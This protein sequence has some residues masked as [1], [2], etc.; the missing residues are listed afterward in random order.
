MI[1]QY[2]GAAVWR[3]PVSLTGMLSDEAL[4]APDTGQNF[5]YKFLGKIQ[6]TPAWSI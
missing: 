1:I 3:C 4:H 2:L 5:Q 6:K